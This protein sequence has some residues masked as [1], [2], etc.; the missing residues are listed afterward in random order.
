MDVIL[1]RKKP[2]KIDTLQIEIPEPEPIV[3]L[4]KIPEPQK[5]IEPTINIMSKVD[6]KLITTQE[7]NSLNSRLISYM[8]GDEN[9]VQGEILEFFAEEKPKIIY[10]TTW[11]IGIMTYF[12]FI[13]R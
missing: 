8:Q 9:D 7:D 4:P 13:Y 6:T 2:Q 12:L 5:E 10:Q 11:V 3:E 1:N